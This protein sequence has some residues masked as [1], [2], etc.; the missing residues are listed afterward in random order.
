MSSERFGSERI[1]LLPSGEIGQAL[2]SLSSEWLNAGIINSIHWLFPDQIG[3]SNDE[4]R[5]IR[6]LH[7]WVD[8]ESG[9]P[10]VEEKDLFQ[11]ISL[12][13]PAEITLAALRFVDEPYEMGVR[14]TTLQESFLQLFALKMPTDSLIQGRE[15][16]GIKQRTLNLIFS[17]N[18]DQ[19][20]TRVQSITS[21]YFEENIFIAHED[22]ENPAGVDA[23]KPLDDQSSY[24]AFILSNLVSLLGGWTGIS[25]N[26]L[27][28]ALHRGGAANDIKVRVARS[29]V[30]IVKT[31]S[32]TLQTAADAAEELVGRQSPLLDPFLSAQVS[33]LEV[34]PPEKTERVLE[35][36]LEWVV[37]L[38]NGA[39][40]YRR[41]TP[42]QLSAPQRKSVTGL[43]IDFW[44]FSFDKIKIL[45]ILIGRSLLAS[46]SRRQRDLYLGSDS[47]TEVDA[48][49]DLRIRTEDPGLADSID[50]LRVEQERAKVMIA[51]RPIEVTRV[52]APGLWGKMR[53][54]FIALVDGSTGPNGGPVV[55]SEEQKIQVLADINKLL[56]RPG[57]SWVFSAN[58]ESAQT[59]SSPL[60]RSDVEDTAS[61][62]NAITEKISETENTEKLL[63]QTRKVEKERAEELKAKYEQLNKRLES[64]KEA[65]GFSDSKTSSSEIDEVR[66]ALD[67]ITRELEL[68]KSRSDAIQRRNSQLSSDKD[69]LAREKDSLDSWI[70]D[71]HFALSAKLT[72]HLISQEQELAVEEKSLAEFTN[73]LSTTH[74]TRAGKLQQNF[75]RNLRIILLFTTLFVVAFYFLIRQIRKTQDI[76]TFL[77]TALWVLILLWIVIFFISLVSILRDYYKKWSRL[78]ELVN[79][80]M[81][82][83]RWVLQSADHIRQERAR[84]NGLFPQV[85]GELE[86]LGYLIHHPWKVP[87]NL[88]SQE[89]FVPAVENLPNHLQIAVVGDG[90]KGEGATV[91]RQLLANA[92]KPGM[93]RESIQ[94]L[95]TDVEQLLS[96]PQ[97]SLTWDVIDADASPSGPRSYLIKALSTTGVVEKAGTKKVRQFIREIQGYMGSSISLP[98]V[99]QL[100]KVNVSGG[101]FR[102]VFDSREEGVNWDKFLAQA[103]IDAN[104]M[105]PGTFTESA[106][107]EYRPESSFKSVAS[108]PARIVPLA[109]S[110]VKCASGDPEHGYAVEIA[111]RIDITDELPVE[112]IRSFE[113]QEKSSNL[114]EP[115]ED[116]DDGTFRI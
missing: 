51:Q 104:Q 83:V 116:Q 41:P 39:L 28:E 47:E 56:P 59:A 95:L 103:V 99:I 79:R 106:R 7:T 81:A 108:V 87:T 91:R 25:N 23:W 74:L 44:K 49:I 52:A 110:N 55:R 82:Q 33:G 102:S 29:F 8:P 6:S 40:T 58:E 21:K 73:S 53:D 113:I 26:I 92:I 34:I 15:I 72:N 31:E 107:L 5:L 96:L 98:A 88:T 32:F 19:R 70:S 2:V 45:P 54:G 69:K 38:E 94:S 27:P 20:N 78:R 84:I 57:D 50:S 35:K 93:R 46:F 37:S 1:V 68:S 60:R 89:R 11:W 12:L 61:H 114:V 67:G 22:R 13:N 77:S 80:S 24:V 36:E 90:G 71:Q 62:M 97:N 10:T 18:K 115:L 112:A 63:E 16:K 14:T 4:D 101:N 76:P 100:Q 109:S 43:Q 30:R 86:L 105:A 85:K 9:M 65:S 17:S 111:C 66:Q 64:L 3:N 75:L 48:R 42:L